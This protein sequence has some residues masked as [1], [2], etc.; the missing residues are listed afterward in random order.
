VPCTGTGTLARNPEIRLRL[1]V[2]ELARQSMRQKAILRN[3]LE[4]LAPGGRL[5]Y[6]TCSMEPEENELVLEDVLATRAVRQLPV[7]PLL[8][9]VAAAGALTQDSAEELLRTGV[10]KNA[11]RTLPGTH[12][13]DGFYAVVLERN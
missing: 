10:R 9:Q 11:L 5:V 2:A 7:Q 12:A 8:E 6:S 13:C 4:Q 3:A 1:E